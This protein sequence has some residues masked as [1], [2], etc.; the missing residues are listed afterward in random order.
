MPRHNPARDWRA[1]GGVGVRCGMPRTD[2]VCMRTRTRTDCDPLGCRP[3]AAAAAMAMS[4]AH[5]CGGGI[6]GG[7]GVVAV[8]MHRISHAVLCVWRDE[9]VR[10]AGGNGV[11]GDGGFAAIVC[12]HRVHSPVPQACFSVSSVAVRSSRLPTET[13]GTRETKRLTT[14]DV[15]S[16]PHIDAVQVVPSFRAACFMRWAVVIQPAGFIAAVLPGPPECASSVAS[17]TVT[18]TMD[19][20][21][22]V[23]THPLGVIVVVPP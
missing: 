3:C 9:C 22:A 1:V 17:N 15:R 14:H 10:W 13:H 21:G 12:M 7:T 4:V 20:H 6:R 16:R 23:V 2:T 5:R 8:H 11:R 19:G 18:G